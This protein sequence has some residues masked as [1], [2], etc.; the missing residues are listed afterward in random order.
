MPQAC[1]SLLRASRKDKVAGSKALMEG[2][3]KSALR[4]VH[5]GGC[6]QDDGETASPTGAFQVDERPTPGGWLV[7]G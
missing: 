1:C 2:C 3:G 5:G 7:A 6:A 4:Y